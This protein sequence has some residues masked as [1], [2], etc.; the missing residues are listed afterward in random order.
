MA[1][2]ITL[3]EKTTA[4]TINYPDGGVN[5]YSSKVNITWDYK[6][7]ERIYIWFN[8]DLFILDSKLYDS[9]NRVAV[10]FNNWMQLSFDNAPALS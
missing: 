9:A 7:S 5:I 6:K 1:I 10:E 8:A 4:E 2:S 3:Y